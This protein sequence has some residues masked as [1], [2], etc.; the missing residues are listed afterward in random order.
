M[1]DLILN[2]Q[3]FR[4]K[5]N[6]I[7]LE[8]KR[9][10]ISEDDTWFNTALDVIGIIDPTGIADLSNAV[11]RYKNANSWD[12]YL[13]AFLSL[14]SAIP[15]FGDVV[16]KPLMGAAQFSKIP[17]SVKK[18]MELANLGKTTDAVKLLEQAANSNTLIDK[19]VKAAINWADKLK[20]AIDAIP[21]KKLSGGGRK[22]IKDWLD[23]FIN[24]GK[25]RATL[26]TT[27]LAKA[28]QVAQAADPQT[29]TKILKVFNNEL[30]KGLSKS[31]KLD[32]LKNVSFLKPWSSGWMAKYV[33]P[34]ATF[35]LIYRN[36]ELTGLINRTKFY[37]GFVKFLQ[38][39]LGSFIP[40]NVSINLLPNY[41][42]ENELDSKFKEYLNSPE[43][44]KYWDE[45]MQGASIPSKSQLSQEASQSKP[46]TIN[47]SKISN[48]PILS[49]IDDI[50]S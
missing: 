47:L 39:T 17:R 27:T 20:Y 8:E 44:Q 9:N 11:I 16:A 5:I 37:W 29:A 50:F 15:Y 38:Q 2:E 45:D 35:G 1:G 3:Q 42:S 21:F 43:G 26:K 12:D 46:S 6:Q 10:L 25:K 18:S 13:F 14:V 19:L 23:L 4:K 41:V 48:D 24:V 22:M 36:R 32:R 40:D 49:L 28:A 33:W 31:T 34:G 7:Y 30:A